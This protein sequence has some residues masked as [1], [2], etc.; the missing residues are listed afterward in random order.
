MRKRSPRWMCCASDSGS[1]RVS[2]RLE[3]VF[4]RVAEVMAEDD[5]RCAACMFDAIL[6]L[7]PAGE[8]APMHQPMEI[9]WGS[10]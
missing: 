8:F 5:H 6:D 9:G 7:L 3:A 10:A 2:P 1:L 4:D